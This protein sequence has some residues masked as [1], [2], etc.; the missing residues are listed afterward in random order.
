MLTVCDFLSYSD[1]KVAKVIAHFTVGWS[2]I[3]SVACFEYLNHFTR[4]NNLFDMIFVVKH[5][6]CSCARTSA[7]KFYSCS[8][9]VNRNI[10]FKLT[11]F[12][13]TPCLKK[14]STLHLAP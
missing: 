3:R 5:V 14:S 1:R 6:T 2:F 10:L 9:S 4:T 13:Y 12:V 7:K 8:I 11:V